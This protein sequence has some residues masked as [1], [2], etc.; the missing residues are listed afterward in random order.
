M[1]PMTPP[2]PSRPLALILLLALAA[3]AALAQDDAPRLAAAGRVLDLPVMEDVP[4]QLVY[5][6]IA[7]EAG[8][9]VVS[10]SNLRGNPTI[11]ID[12]DGRTVEQALDLATTLA[13]H[14][15]VAMA[16]DSVLVAAD[17]PQNRRT[18]EPMG[19]RLFALENADPR[20]AVT[21]LRS[22][23]GLRSI[24]LEEDRAT[25]TVRDT[26]AKLAAT[27][28]LLALID[29][30]PWEVEVDV[31]LLEIPE[32]SL[33]RRMADREWSRLEPA[34]LSGLLGEPGAVVLGN[35]LLGAV[36]RKELAVKVLSAGPAASSS[37]V[38]G[39]SRPDAAPESSTLELSGKARVHGESREVTLDFQLQARAKHG[40]EIVTIELTASVRLPETE[41]LLLPVLPPPGSPGLLG[42]GSALALV[43][44]PRILSDGDVRPE[45]LETLWIGTEAHIRE[46]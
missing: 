23:L 16:A 40:R 18:H 34:A 12:L 33:R 5:A 31:R 26:L 29:R 3:P 38:E 10:D 8:I 30:R 41:S 27:E 25:I 20:D 13:G 42:D 43:L 24:A 19:L 6:A 9:H 21:I 35:G 4:V 45:D 44:T 11:S 2:R 17:T 39:T 1:T 46:P 14:F 28:R 22:L 15:W 32:P 37:G 36:G 7:R